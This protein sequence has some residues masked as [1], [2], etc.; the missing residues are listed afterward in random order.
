MEAEESVGLVGAGRMALAIATGILAAGNVKPEQIIASAPSDNNLCKFKEMGMRTTHDNGSVVKN[1]TVLFLAVKPHLLT[2]VLVNICPLV[3]PAHLVVSVAAGVTIDTLESLL[4]QGCR[5]LRMMPNLPCTVLQGASVFCRGTHAT[6]SDADLLKGL[7]SACG[8]CEETP[9]SYID[10]HTGVYLF[11]EAL[12]D[13]AVKM[14]MPYEL[15]KKLVAHTLL[16]AGKMMLDSGE[17]PAKL[18]S[19]VCTP[20]GTTVHGLYQLEKGNLRSTVMDAVGAATD[21]AR[22]V[23]KRLQPHQGLGQR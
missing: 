12:I 23:G 2:N 11:A 14:G 3:T 21:H 5:V 4:P 7:V 1:C 18:K 10:I 19:D 17:H 22:E 8:L 9:E 13:G 20:G 6:T 15:S 16:G